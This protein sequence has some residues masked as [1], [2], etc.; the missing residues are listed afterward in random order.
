MSKNKFNNNGLKV[1][2]ETTIIYY[3]DFN[4]KE[5][6]AVDEINN[7][8]G[9]RVSLYQTDEKFERYDIKKAK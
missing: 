4:H 3:V 6:W 7:L 5:L 1:T 2:V 9:E 8:T